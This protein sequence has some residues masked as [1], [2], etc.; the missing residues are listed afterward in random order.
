M[1]KTIR[2]VTLVDIEDGIDPTDVSDWISGHLDNIDYEMLDEMGL[3]HE[4][5]SV[6]ISYPDGTE[7][8][9]AAHL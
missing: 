8:D 4:D 9:E 7:S 2:I 5:V 3:H 1:S 6:G